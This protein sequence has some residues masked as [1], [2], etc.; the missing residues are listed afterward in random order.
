MLQPR[1]ITAVVLLA[2]IITALAWGRPAAWGILMLPVMAL[3]VNEW[4]RLIWQP[5]L[6]IVLATVAAGILYILVR[7]PYLPA[8]PWLVLPL[9]VGLGAWMAVAF[10]SIYRVKP[11]TTPPWLVGVFM[12]QLWVSLY[13]LRLSGASV[14]I[15]AMA[16]VWLADIGAYF[17]GRAFGQRKLAPRVSPGKTWEG[18]WGGAVLC[19][20]IAVLL[21][22]GGAGED[23][24]RVS[25]FTSVLAE[26][27]GLPGMAVVLLA[28]V[29]L[30]V[31]G[32]L[33][34]SLLKRHAGVKDSG[35]CL[36]GHGGMFDRIDALVPTMP[37]CLII[38]LIL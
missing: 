22:R 34:E 8:S 18:V 15:S 31:T 33:Y 28:L 26:H 16:I 32:D 4:M 24:D 36:P 29:G 1:I 38:W 27:A 12:F 5:S 19:V 13:E 30:S 14:L 9:A 17:S 3:A 11:V 25:L 37:A 7:D 20:A 6:R 23:S 10:R 2:I 21:A 35:A